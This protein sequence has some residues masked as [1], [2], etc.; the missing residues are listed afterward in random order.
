MADPLRLL[1]STVWER[2]VEKAQRPPLELREEDLLGI[3]VDLL[4]QLYPTLQILDNK[5]QELIEIGWKER[6]EKAGAQ[7]A[8]AQ[9][10]LSDSL[11]AGAG[12]G[13]GAPEL[14]AN[15]LSALTGQAGGATGAPGPSG[16]AP[17]GPDNRGDSRYYGGG[18]NLAALAQLNSLGGLGGPG[19]VGP[20]GGAGGLKR[21]ASAMDGG[22]GAGGERYGGD[23]RGD[24]EPEWECQCG[25][26][27]WATRP[28]CRKCGS[29]RDGEA[30]P[31]G[32]TTMRTAYR[33]VGCAS[34]PRPPPPPPQCKTVSTPHPSSSFRGNN[35]ER[36]RKGSCWNCGSM[37]HLKVECPY[38]DGKAAPVCL[39]VI[40]SLFPLTS[41][42]PSPPSRPSPPTKK[43][44]TAQTIC[45]CKYQKGS[46]AYENTGCRF[47][48]LPV[49]TCH[50]YLVGKCNDKE[51]SLTH[52]EA[53]ACPHVFQKGTCM[54]GKDCMLADRPV[55]ECC[56]PT[57]MRGETCRRRHQFHKVTDENG[58]K[59][60]VH[61]TKPQHMGKGKGR[62]WDEGGG[63]Y[64]KGRKGGYDRGYDRG[65][66]DYDEQGGAG[67]GGGGGKGFDRSYDDGGGKGG[68]DGG[69]GGFDRGYG[70]GGGG[71]SKGYG[72]KGYSG[73]R[74]FGGGGG[75]GG[76]DN[77]SGM[78]GKGMGGG[79]GG[80]GGGGG[81]KGMGGG[82]D[83]RGG[84]GFP[85]MGGKGAPPPP[86][87]DSGYGPSGGGGGGGGGG[88]P[89]DRSK[90]PRTSYDY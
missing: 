40:P 9:A 27:N 43:N 3:T 77:G 80:Y 15:A 7:A 81:G 28:V 38:L 90:M 5:V 19:A 60:Y 42:P 67:G 50:G 82:Y 18:A 59:C 4:R 85:A 66:D 71:G 32:P 87:F 23:R 78:G 74:G 37:E 62:R 63:G 46:C 41:T 2:F 30:G 44:T 6:K 53:P 51:C 84:K 24:G 64:G 79:G 58:V 54:F 39:L 65:Y 88:Y 45:P 49:S 75:G 8:A 52:L 16:P 72:G 21:P 14:L 31:A 86:S 57:C 1:A 17:A 26:T 61:P 70:G 89:A 20:I 73:D 47:L 83:D 29:P 34:L 55:D 25:N 48:G 12:G 56:F 11:A 33:Y 10:Q 35:N 76:F 69:K 22:A 13:G 68:F 36:V